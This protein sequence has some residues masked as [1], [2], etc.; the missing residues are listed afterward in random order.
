MRR[1]G[2]LEALLSALL[3]GAATPVSK[4]LL[5]DVGPQMLAGLFYLGAA[6]CLAPLLACSGRAGSRFAL[7]RDRVNRLRLA[8][9]IAF[10]GVIGPLLLLLGLERARAASVAMLLNL[11]TTAT[12][13][14]AFFLFREHL[15][16]WAWLGNAGVLASGVLLSLEGGRPGWLGSL[17]VAGAALAWGLDNNLTARIDGIAPAQCTFWKGL[18]AGS[19]HLGA[20]LWLAPSS[21]RPIWLAALAVGGLSYGLSIVLYIRSAQSLGAARS[22]MIFAAAPF[23]GVLLAVAWLGESL[24]AAQL[25]AGLLLALSLG[26]CLSERHAHAHAHEPLVHTH[27]HDHDDGHHDHVHADGQA[28]AR[29]A[30][31][32]T[33]A[34]IEHSHAHWPDLHHRHTHG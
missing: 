5:A 16:K 3:F 4:R 10:G 33:H 22:Q 7:P 31:E 2:I 9:A 13:L 30:H 24:S 29:H 20:A 27:E 21:P 14:L 34:A 32:H 11:E 23:F 8:G 1:A 17:L 18:V 26:V 19:T 28:A 12:A 15:G 25:A 6:I